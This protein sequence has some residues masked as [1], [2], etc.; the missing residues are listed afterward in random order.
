MFGDEG[1]YPIVELAGPLLENYREF[2][3]RSS[4]NYCPADGRV[5]DFMREYLSDVCDPRE[6]FPSIPHKTFVLDRFGT[7]RML[8]LPP[9]CDRHES[10]FVSSYRVRQGVLNNPRS[11]RRTTA[12]VFHV[13][14]GG[15]PVPADKKS[16]PKAVFKNLWA[17]AFDAPDE[18]LE[19]PF[20]STRSARAGRGFPSTCARP[21]AR[22]FRTAR[23]KKLWRYAFSPRGRSYAIS[24]SS[25]AFSATRA[26][27]SCGK[28]TRL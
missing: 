20:T 3:M 11:D 17:R 10:P 19:L 12:G 14:E 8:S 21:C 5:M 28:T 23:E 27:R 7:A 9:D 25:R 18:L 24:I 13:A 22:R 15:L 6:A 1:D 26:I 2:A 4:E 16:V